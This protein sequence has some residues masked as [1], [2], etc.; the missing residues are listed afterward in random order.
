MVVKNYRTVR[1][2][3]NHYAMPTDVDVRRA[4]DDFS[5]MTSRVRRYDDC[6]VMDFGI[7]RGKLLCFMWSD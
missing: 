5:S 7:T 4:F 1:R 3:K 2:R 6:D